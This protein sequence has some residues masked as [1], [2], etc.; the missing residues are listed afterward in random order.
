MG[1]KKI[2]IVDDDVALC[3]GIAELLLDE[4][5]IVTNTSNPFKGKELIK[6]QHFDL[7]LLDY[8]MSGLTGIDLLK[9]INTKKTKVFFISGRPFLDKV[10]QE[11]GVSHLIEGIIN[12]PFLAEDLLQKINTLS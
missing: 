12:K 8:K 9:D 3:D 1:I 2:L 7:A 5:Y 6:T 4:G 10:L 11:A